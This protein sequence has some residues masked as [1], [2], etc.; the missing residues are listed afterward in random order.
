MGFTGFS[1]LNDVQ[2]VDENTGWVVGDGGT[3][4]KTIDGRTWV[5]QTS[6]TFKSLKSVHFIDTQRGW[7][8][9]GNAFLQTTDGQSWTTGSV[10][11]PSGRSITIG[12]LNEV[13]FNSPT[14]GWML[15]KDIRIGGGFS[16]EVLRTTD[17]GTRWFE[18]PFG[19]SS[20]IGLY[21]VNENTGWVVGRFGR[22][23][24]LAEEPNPGSTIAGRAGSTLIILMTSGGNAMVGPG[25]TATIKSD[26]IEVKEN[27][28]T[29][30]TA[31]GIALGRM[32]VRTDQT[33][34]VGGELADVFFLDTGTGWAVG[35]DG[36]IIKTT[37]G[38]QTWSRQTSGTT[39]YLNAI[40]FADANHGWAVG[41]DGNILSTA[42]G[43]TTWTKIIWT[44]ERFGDVIPV[45]LTG[46]HAVDSDHA[47]AVDTSGEII[48]YAPI[49]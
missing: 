12:S 44:I 16:H 15:N 49:P 32:V 23:T 6:G 2:F 41:R 25:Q 13:H 42:D 1:S 48:R 28:G 7:T 35:Q 36:V 22:L 5:Q 33:T 40:H 14:R 34:G 37:N 38:G 11:D 30:T 45:F 47:W 4:L 20:M 18:I 8:S 9:G 43:G 46:V 39:S 24:K 26:R 31:I 29:T 19:G 17:S 10:K 21:F 27:F 3:I